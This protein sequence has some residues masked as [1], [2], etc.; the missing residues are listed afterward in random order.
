MY[1]SLEIREPEN[2]LEP[3][4]HLSGRIDASGARRL[5]DV[6]TQL[7]AAGTERLVISL[8]EVRFVSSTGLGHFLVIAEDFQAEG[9]E[10]VFAEPANSVRHVLKL[11]NL[12]QFLV[13]VDT[14][15]EA[16]DL[17]PA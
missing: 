7:R 2:A 15:E 13:L 5:R 11:L 9:G 16:L 10:V 8:K 1:D 17:Q 3:V 6:C 14:V 12:E 4:L